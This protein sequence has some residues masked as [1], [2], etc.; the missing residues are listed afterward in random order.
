M[1]H[2]H[3]VPAR[4]HFLRM[5]ARLAG[6][7]ISSLG[8]EPARQFFVRD[9]QAEP[10]VT[11]YK[12]LVCVYMFGGNDANNLIVPVD[13]YTAYSAA[14]GGTAGVALPANTLLPIPG[15]G[16]ATYGLHPSVSELATIYNAG[17]LAFVLNM[18]ALNRPLTKQLY[19]GGASRPPNLFS[20]SDQTTQ[21][22]TGS[23]TQRTGWG[24]RLLDL[25]GATD[26]LSAVSVSSPAIFLDGADVRS[27]VVPPGA[28]L[29]L[30]GM[31]FWP[32]SGADARRQAV[33]AM[34]LMDGGN[35]VR[36]AANQMFAD[37][38]QLAD[39]LSA[40]GGLLPNTSPFPDSSLGNQL[41][42]VTRL[43][44]V[45][46]QMG[47]GR[48]VFFCSSGGFDTHAAQLGHHANLLRNL[49]QAVSAFAMATVDLGLAGQV[50]TFTQSE[51]SRSTQ[52][53]GTG[54]DHAWGSHHI[55]LGGA[56]RGGI[57]GA[58]PDFVLGGDQ[59]ASNRGVWIPA[60]GSVQFGATLGRWFGAT[61]GELAW[62]FPNLANFSTPD[63]GF[64]R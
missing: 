5:S 43:I 48:Q 50:T 18:G 24:G 36:E 8:L 4:R 6:L 22:Q 54:T 7:G 51:F 58:M 52:T 39:T 23:A 16:G 63:L 57:Y 15:P 12:A 62:A 28:N 31:N 26:S 35:P 30:S 3:N 53:N 13:N 37:G 59:D 2:T 60:I 61:P 9:V 46:S 21:A 11:D 45:R 44:R 56:V 10:R 55:V 27:N 14:R 19:Q 33:N 64:M 1:R 20:H 40:S 17:Y 38:L 29:G 47:P 49:S 42:E 41:R 32:S 25:F 34:V